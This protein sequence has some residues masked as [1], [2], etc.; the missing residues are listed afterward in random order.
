MTLV[1]K[2]DYKLAFPAQIREWRFQYVSSTYHPHLHTWIVLTVGQDGEFY[3][4][5]RE[6]IKVVNKLEQALE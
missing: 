5:R 3:P 2:P 6:Q 1:I 4:F